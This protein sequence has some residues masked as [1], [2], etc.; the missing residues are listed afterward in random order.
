[1]LEALRLSL[2][3]LPLALVACKAVEP[4][5]RP[6]DTCVRACKDRIARECSEDECDRGCHFILDRLVEREGKA[7]LDCMGKQ[8]SRCDDPVWAE[9]AAKIGVHGDGGPPA[10]PPPEEE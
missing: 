10:P 7:V 1:M 4:P 8:T 5:D 2:V 3:L 9:C 6:I